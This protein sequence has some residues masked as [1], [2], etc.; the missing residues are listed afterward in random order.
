M[1]AEDRPGTRARLS[2]IA[3]LTSVVTARRAVGLALV[4]VV[5]G[6]ALAVPVQTYL[7]QREQAAAIAREHDSLTRDIA[8]LRGEQARLDDPAAIEEECRRRL[9]CVKPGETPLLV[10]GP[11]SGAPRVDD[12][13]A[14][15]EAPPRWYSTLLDSV[16]DPG[17]R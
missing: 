6:L 17:R 5:L 16:A 14:D 9:R 1:T 4:L 2:R 10:E 3:G 15:D 11:G 13:K 12:R 7:S 8:R